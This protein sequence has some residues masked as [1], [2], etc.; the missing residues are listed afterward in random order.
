ME[1]FIKWIKSS[2][3][4]FVLFVMILV[5]ANIASHKAFLRFDLT[6][7]GSYSISQASRSTV[8]TLTEPLSVKVFFSDNLPAPYNTTSQYVKDILVEYKGAANR[9]FS[10]QFFNMNKP[11]NQKIAQSYGLRQV[12]IQ[13]VKNSEVGFK[14]VWMGL[15]ITYGD[16]IEVIDGI[17]SDSGFEYNLT[18][19]ISKMIAQSDTLAGLGADDKITLTLYASDDLK[20]FRISGYDDVSAQVQAAFNKVNQKNLN[21]L[22]YISKNPQDDEIQEAADLYGLQLFKWQE[23]DGSEGKGAFGLVIGYGENFRT[24]PLSIQ[25][26]LFGYGISGLQNLEANISDSLESLLSKST[27]IGYLT[28]HDEEGL[29]NE[30]GEEL[31]F[32]KLISDMYEFKE[33]NLAEEEIPS[34]LDTI[35]INGPKKEIPQEELYKLDQFIMKGGNVM[36]FADPFQVEQGGYYQQPN[37]KPIKNGLNTLLESY[38]AKLESN[39]VFDEQ[40]YVYQGQGYGNVKMYWAPMLQK[41]QISQKNVITKNL[42]YVIFLQPGTITLDAEKAGKNVKATVLAKTSPKAWVETENFQISPQ[43]QAPYDKTREK[44]ENIAVL[45][46]GKF[47]SAFEKNPSEKDDGDEKSGLSTTTHLS[48]GTRKGKIFVANT[49]YITSNQLINESGNEPIA[50]FIRNGVDYLNGNNDLCTMRTKGLSLNTLSNTGTLLALIVKYFNQFGL[51]VLVAIAGFIV[52]RMRIIR[53]RSIHFR[54][55]PNDSRDLETAK[56]LNKDG[57]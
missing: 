38:G 37:Y 32:K 48:T 17:T 10:Y 22:S 42:G 41:K 35:V 33:L 25:R 7:Q 27:V 9:N 39:Y 29:S 44:A 30:N 19:K 21:R 40:C 26:S 18:T 43:M 49:S 46:E 56:S 55:N 47:N 16:S 50:M 11:E 6:S 13:Q 20:Q 52:W 45:L 12:Q 2:A 28:G 8:K 14:Q 36:I 1:K 57:E 3:S 34:N 51:A 5:L 53:R 31:N 4:D 24:I 15:A 23:K 54:Y